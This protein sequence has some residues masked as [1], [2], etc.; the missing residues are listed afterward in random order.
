MV[1]I[2]SNDISLYETENI[3]LPNAEVQTVHSNE[4]YSN[5]YYSVENDIN[6]TNE[7]GSFQCH[8]NVEVPQSSYSYYCPPENKQMYIISEINSQ[9][10]YNPV[11]I[12]SNIQQNNSCKCSNDVH[13]FQKNPR[14]QRLAFNRSMRS[15]RPY[16]NSYMDNSFS[17][18]ICG[19]SYGSS[20]FQSRENFNHGNFDRSQSGKNFSSLTSSFDNSFFNK[21]RITNDK[22]ILKI[23]IC[24][25]FCFKNKCE[26]FPQCTLSHSRLDYE[27]SLF[28]S[29]EGHQN[30]KIL[31]LREECKYFSSSGKCLNGLTCEYM[32]KTPIQ[33]VETKNQEEIINNLYEEDGLYQDIF[34]DSDQ[35]LSSL[36]MCEFYT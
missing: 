28:I 24:P 13:T 14:R 26:L 33:I 10:V 18:S 12:Q 2:N 25:S 20:L 7:L 19:S 36:N 21:V 3:A 15:N 31:L 9:N 32:H 30:Q 5:N 22:E 29:N 35:A 27:E 16:S 8:Q 11:Q 4:F 17:N 1:N 34:N 6:H 23:G